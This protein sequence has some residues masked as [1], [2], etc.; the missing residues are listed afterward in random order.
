[1]NNVIESAAAAPAPAAAPSTASVFVQ[2]PEVTLPGG[3]VVPA[4][5]VGQ[6]FCSKGASGLAEVTATGAPWV[7]INYHQAREA[8][9]VAGFKLLTELQALAIAFDIASQGANWTG[10][11]V[12]EGKLFQGLRKWSVE[13]AQPGEYAPE[14]ADEQ[15]WFVLSNGSRICDASG[16]LFSWIFDDVQGDEQGIVARAFATDSPSIA[17]APFP[18]MQ[19]GMGWRPDAGR[20][21][22][23]D[24]LFRGGFRYDEAVAGVFRL[25]SDSPGSCGDVVGFRCTK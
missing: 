13:K 22:S 17:T 12:G 23:G 4:F 11:A 10:G 25:R 7:R 19:K 9:A 1:M 3:I 20:D 16:N 15:R 6:Y 5:E 21:W 2:V 14:D 8:C 18:S 24:A